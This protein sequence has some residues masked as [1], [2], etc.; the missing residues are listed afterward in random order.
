MDLQEQSTPQSPA[1][2]EKAHVEAPHIVEKEDPS[3]L[4]RTEVRQGSRPGDVRVRWVRPTHEAFRRRSAGVLEATT[5]AE[6]PRTSLERVTTTIKRALIGA[7]LATARAEHERLNKFQA[8]AVLSSDAIS[9]VAYA[10]EAILITLVAAGSGNLW[11]TLFICLAIVGLLSIVALSYRQTIPAYPNGG[12]SYIVAKD[13]LGT[14]PG[15][16]AAASLMI[17]YV[18]TVSVSIAAGVQALATLFP[19]LAPNVVPIDIAL[20]LLITIVNLRGVRES[21]AIFSLPT[22]VFI[23]SALL[24]IL[25]GCIKAFLFQHQPLFGHF[26][27]VR[28]AE[29]LGLF[30]ILRSFADGCAAMTGTEAISNGIP[31]FRKPE[32]RNAAITLTWMAVILGTLFIGITI[33]ALAYG[34]EAN[35]TGNPTVIGQIAQLV[36]IGPLFFMYPVFQFATL[37]ILTLAANTS[38]SDFP[39]LSSLLARDHYLP[40]QFAFRG[41]RLAFSTGIIFLAILASILLVVFNGNTTLLINLYAVGVFLSF[42]LSQG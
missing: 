7:P 2:N 35:P 10:T 18:L 20:V 42:T 26:Q 29:G 33:L 16:V 39:R 1:G 9:S 6:A 31:A 3:F 4:M 21:G 32:A 19:S 5:E 30:L 11:L 25:V 38:Y 13:N 17:D 14:L 22:Y 24:L 28:P 41:D 36:F 12:G 34:T 23:G 15:L 27:Y 40:H 37:F 8:L